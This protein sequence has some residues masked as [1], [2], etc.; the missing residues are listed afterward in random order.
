VFL[1]VVLSAKILDRGRGAR[2]LKSSDICRADSDFS[3]PVHCTRGETDVLTFVPAKP[4]FRDEF[5][6]FNFIL[7][8]SDA[9]YV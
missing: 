6:G 8:I 5:V 3:A 2:K 9:C 4:N 7:C 1:H